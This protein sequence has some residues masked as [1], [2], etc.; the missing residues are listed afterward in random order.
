[1]EKENKIFEFKGKY[2]SAIGRRK[3]A[4]AQVRLYKNG[5]GRVLINNQ[6][7]HRYFTVPSYTDAILK[8]LKIS[9]LENALDLSIIIQG[10]GKRGQADAVKHGV[11]RALLLVDKNLKPALKVESLL[12]R[13]PRKKER[14][15]PGLKKARR[16]E[17]WS[18]R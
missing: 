15:K 11:A 17:Q 6:E 7:L 5:E 1:M 2:V 8:M 18:K 3:Q 10:G 16:A 12:T 14:K 9:G 4:V 13:D